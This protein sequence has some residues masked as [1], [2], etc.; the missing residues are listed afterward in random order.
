MLL[1]SSL[2]PLR[3]VFSLA[4]AALALALG[5]GG[6]VGAAPAHAAATSATSPALSGRFRYVGPSSQAA[7]IEAGIEAA[8]AS[9]PESLQ[10]VARRRLKIATAIPGA[11]VLEVGEEQ[12]RVSLDARTITTKPG[13]TVTWADGTGSLSRVTHEVGASGLTE[14]LVSVEGTRENVYRV[15]EDGRALTMAVTIRS[16]HLAAP[17]RYS[18]SYVRE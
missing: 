8:I 12:R 18:L 13:R 2:Q 9:L 1:R 5:V 10:P 4:A 15:G 14:R 11:V 7:T 6:A 17:I 16:P 3:P